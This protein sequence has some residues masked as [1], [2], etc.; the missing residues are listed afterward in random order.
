MRSGFRPLL[1]AGGGHALPALVVVMHCLLSL[2]PERASAPRGLRRF[3]S[4]P[5]VAHSA[6]PHSAPAC[7]ARH[8][9]V[10]LLWRACGR[11]KA[12]PDVN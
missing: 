8:K 3:V 6:T 9:T 10:W 7:W 11:G 1:R 2:Y 5:T 4:V 12:A